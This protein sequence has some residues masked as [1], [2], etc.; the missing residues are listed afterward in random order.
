MKYD[1][2]LEMV[3]YAEAHGIKPAARQ[4]GCQVKIARKWLR[5]WLEANR[6]RSAL[7]DRSRA[8]RRCPH[9]IAARVERQIVRERKKA[10]C[11]GPARLQEFCAI[12]AGLGAIARVIRQ[13]GLTRRRKTKPQKKRDMRELKA[14]FAPFEQAQVDVK[15]LNDIPFYVEQIWRNGA[16]PRFQ[17]SWRDVKTGGVFLGFAKELSEE[18]AC[19][20]VHAVNDH[21]HRTGTVL[22][23]F[24]TIQTDNGSEFSGAE[25]Q[26]DKRRGFHHA[27]EHAIGAKHRFIPPGKKNYQADVESLHHRIEEEFFDFE[28]FPDHNVFFAKASAWQLW[29]NSTRKNLY[30]GKRSSDDILLQDAPKRNPAVWILPAIDLDLAVKKKMGTGG[31]YVP[32]LP[33]NED[34]PLASA[35]VAGDSS[36]LQGAEAARSSWR[37]PGVNATRRDQTSRVRASSATGRIRGSLSCESTAGLETV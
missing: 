11:L 34:S 3:R 18:H 37:V 2:R 7:A 30:K 13:R 19:C 24:A 10:P 14:R 17:Y 20:F 16:L 29:W 1:R 12:P 22:R 26:L 33:E 8:P 32:A 36:F 27:I 21:L 5:R 6:A 31:C 28:T 25:R 4:Y 35:A 9:K 15:Y 23:G